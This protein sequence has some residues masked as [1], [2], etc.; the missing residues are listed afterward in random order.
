MPRGNRRLAAPLP[1]R[2]TSGS[3]RLLSES[4]PFYGAHYYF[5]SAA[6]GGTGP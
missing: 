6:A 2:P 4:A 3:P 5:S 1:A